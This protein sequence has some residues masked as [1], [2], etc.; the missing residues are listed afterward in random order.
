MSELCKGRV[1]VFIGLIEYFFKIL[2]VL[3][4]VIVGLLKIKFYKYDIVYF[5]LVVFFI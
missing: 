1:L 3:F 5:K 4:D 2:L